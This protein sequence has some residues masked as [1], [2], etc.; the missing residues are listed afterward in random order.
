[1]GAIIIFQQQLDRS[2]RDL[3]QVNRKGDNSEKTDTMQ[4]SSYKAFT[5][6]VKNASFKSNGLC[7]VGV[8]MTPYTFLKS[9]T[10]Q[11]I[12]FNPT[13]AIALII[14]NVNYDDKNYHKLENVKQNIKEVEETIKFLGIKEVKLIDFTEEELIQKIKYL[15]SE[16][17]KS[18]N[19]EKNK[20]FLFVYYAGHGL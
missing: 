19:S 3:K 2:V 8:A 13:Q 16:F 12:P 1:M 6:K 20:T 15:E 7:T 14:G 9:K 11:E 10:H 18:R 17:I 5:T 4:N